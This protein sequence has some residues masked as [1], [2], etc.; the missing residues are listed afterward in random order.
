MVRTALTCCRCLTVDAANVLLPVRAGE[1]K[2]V[3][4]GQGMYGNSV[5]VAAGKT[6]V[7]RLGFR[8]LGVG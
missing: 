4:I 6:W 7:V 3:A 2:M 8:L 1:P 5:E